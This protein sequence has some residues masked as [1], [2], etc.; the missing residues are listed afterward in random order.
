MKKIFKKPKTSTDIRFNKEY[1]PFENQ[2]EY[3]I[4]ANVKNFAFYC[5]RGLAK[6]E[7]HGFIARLK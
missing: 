5:L 1:A 3:A 4:D 6:P 7:K 2:R